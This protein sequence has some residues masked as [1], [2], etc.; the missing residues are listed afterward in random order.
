V[1][2]YQTKEEEEERK[3]EKHNKDSVQE[4]RNRKKER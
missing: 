3:T 1:Q 4:D 2:I